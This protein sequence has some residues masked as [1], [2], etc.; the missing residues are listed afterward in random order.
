MAAPLD[1]CAAVILNRG[2]LLL[3]TRRPGSHLAGKWEFPGGKK[4]E[5]ETLV[6]CIRRELKEELA[7]DIERAFPLFHI[8]HVYPEK[9]IRLHFLEC[10][11]T[12]DT[13]PCPTE[14]QK[15][16]WFSPSQFPLLDW[17]PA[18][19]HIILWLKEL[20]KFQLPELTLVDSM[21]TEQLARS[22]FPAP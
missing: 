16:D 9:T 2:R 5:H 20:H 21:R 7:L 14:G 8:L 13:A 17:V 18:D 22:L 1:V 12:A 3:A 4:E 11:P 19:K 10:I 15:A 6:D